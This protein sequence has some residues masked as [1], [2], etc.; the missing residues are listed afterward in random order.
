MGSEW[1][2]RSF[3][4][5]GSQAAAIWT[6]DNVK[7]PK[8]I[9]DPNIDDAEKGLP[10]GLIVRVFRTHKGVIGKPIT[11]SIQIRNPETGLSTDLTPFG[12]IDAKVDERMIPRKLTSLDGKKIDLYE[13]LVSKN[14][15][16][17][18]VVQCLERGQ[19]F[20]FAR[21]DCYLRL[22]DGSPILNFIKVFISIWVQMV[23]VIS[24]GVAASALLTGPVALLLTV[25]FVLLG[26]FRDF[27]LG[28]ATGQTSEGATFY[29]GGPIESL[30]RL[31]TQQ[32][33]MSPLKA[34]GAEPLVKGVDSVLQFLMQSIAQVLPDFSAYST[35]DFAAYGY[36]VPA[37]RVFQDLTTCLAYVA[38]LAVIGYFLLRTRE[39]AK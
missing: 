18:I 33:V 7:P 31:V 22:P 36:D 16:L 17:Q 20:G 35:V 29:G 26:F 8:F 25:S 4:E 34:G 14:G 13:D 10:I 39:V 9:D 1:T 23:I 38:G 27:F 32:N 3:I 11:G 21:P 5:G 6:F 37:D 24:I 28:I 19:Y 30:V 15:K 12:A 2:Y